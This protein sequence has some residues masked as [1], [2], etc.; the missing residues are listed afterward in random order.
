[1]ETIQADHMFPL[2]THWEESSLGDLSFEIEEEISHWWNTVNT[3][4]AAVPQEITTDDSED[5]PCNDEQLG[6]DDLWSSTAIVTPS[7]KTPLHDFHRV[8]ES[9]FVQRMKRSETDKT[10]PLQSQTMAGEMNILLTSMEALNWKKNH[11]LKRP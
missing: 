8:I 6:R 1:M 10:S 9:S 7:P 3:G 2:S 4:H 11:C 5:L